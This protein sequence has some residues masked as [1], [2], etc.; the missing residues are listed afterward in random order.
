[1]N[2]NRLIPLLLCIGMLLGLTGVSFGQ[3]NT[4]A[5]HETTPEQQVIY[6]DMLN[7]YKENRHSDAR[8]LAKNHLLKFSDLLDTA[9]N[10]LDR[11][12]AVRLTIGMINSMLNAENRMSAGARLGGDAGLL[13]LL[14]RT[15][16]KARNASA[17]INS[18]SEP[19][20]A[21]IQSEVGTGAQKLIQTGKAI[22]AREELNNIYNDFQPELNKKGLRSLDAV[23]NEMMPAAPAEERFLAVSQTEAAQIITAVKNYFNGL[24]N[25]DSARMR[26]ATGADAQGETVLRDKYARDLRE[27]GIARVSSITLPALSKTDMKLQKM[28]NGVHS[29]II[30]GIKLNVVK[31]DGTTDSMVIDKRL[32]FRKNSAGKWIIVVPN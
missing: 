16:V 8:R 14:N 13:R 12:S 30:K 24:V 1:M 10:D 6:T 5:D 32:R 17:N 2:R 22:V 31:A 18:A 23:T 20:K 27:E 28:N 21:Y 3:R 29:L 25:N 15:L 7:A 4:A 11:E 26:S 19:V 9:K